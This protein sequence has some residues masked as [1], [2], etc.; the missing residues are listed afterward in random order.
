MHQGY[1][2]TNHTHAT[3]AVTEQTKEVRKQRQKTE[4]YMHKTH[5][6]EHCN[7]STADIHSFSCEVLTMN[8]VA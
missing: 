6:Y 8:Q 3:T 4:T 1:C 7:V 2:I 5:A